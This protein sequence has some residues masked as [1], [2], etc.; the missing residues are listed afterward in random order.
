[1]KHALQLTA[2][3]SIGW[4]CNQQSSTPTVFQLESPVGPNASLPHLVTGEDD[5]L[6]LSW[7]EKGDSGQVQFYYAS[8][9]NDKW[10]AP[11]RIA[12]GNDWFV[13]WADYPMI[14]VDKA[15]NM[16]AHYLAKSSTGTYS[17]DVNVMYKP[18]GKEWIGP[19]IPHM[20]G[21]PTEHG[22][23]T[24]LPQNDGT[25]LLTWLDGRNTMGHEEHEGHG[26]GAMT[27]RSAV[28]NMQG[29]LSQEM[30]LDGRV[31]D[32]CQTAGV[33]TPAGPIIAYRDRTE[34][35]IRDMA[36]VRWINGTWT[37]PVPVSIDNW[38]ITGCPVNGP[39]LSAWDNTVGMAWFT[40]A[41]GEPKVNVRFSQDHG[42]TFGETHMLS[43]ETVGRVDI[44]M[45]DAS[46]AIVSWLATSDTASYI[47]SR[48]V[49]ANGNQEKSITIAQTSSAR[50]SG[51][52]QLTRWKNKNY[53]AW[54]HL[55]DERSTVRLARV[56]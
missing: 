41:N 54:T 19:V 4:A 23:A 1:M 16:V 17:Y 50:A 52:P 7:I 3:A 13:N 20:D 56:E 35:E 27:I 48:R 25:F 47:M 9:E 14:A 26:G 15:G 2:I 43:N 40:A 24:L 5:Q 37:A 53:F 11:E 31:C 46:S 12:G 10:S 18:V 30:E 42:A 51:F 8:M 34:D 32:C 6:Y 29:Q 44:A 22:F 38:N 55:E 39:R 21:T 33:L 36:M 45:V 28:L 49:D